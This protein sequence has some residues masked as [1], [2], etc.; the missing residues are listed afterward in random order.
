[1]RLWIPAAALALALAPLGVVRPLWVSG[2]SMEPAIPHDS[3]RWALRAWASHAPRRG[4]V[5]LVTGPEGASLKR[6]VGLPGER[7]SWSGPDL[8]VNGQRLAEPW[9]AFPEREGQGTWA[10]GEGYLLL[11]DNRP[12]SRDGRSWGPLPCGSLKGRLLGTAAGS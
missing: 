5:W 10:C 4:E 6:V 7:V 12:L 1:M 11:G 3:L 2:H 9:V 8:A